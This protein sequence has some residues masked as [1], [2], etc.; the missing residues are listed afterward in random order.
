M[1]EFLQPSAP[2]ILRLTPLKY[3]VCTTSCNPPSLVLPFE[4][5]GISWGRFLSLSVSYDTYWDSLLLCTDTLH[6]IK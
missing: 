4:E 1:R 2:S 3:G 5:K 6:M